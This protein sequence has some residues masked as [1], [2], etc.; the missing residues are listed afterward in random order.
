MFI[1]IRNAREGKLTGAQGDDLYLPGLEEGLEN[2]ADLKQCLSN[3]NVPICF[4]N[5]SNNECYDPDGLN[6]ACDL[7][8]SAN[9]EQDYRRISVEEYGH[10]DTLI[11]KDACR[12]VFPVMLDFLDSYANSCTKSTTSCYYQMYKT[13]LSRGMILLIIS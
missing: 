13:F 4:M 2:N 5:G 9:E 12:D 10:L 6:R 3:L 8:K 11:G 7:L 1:F